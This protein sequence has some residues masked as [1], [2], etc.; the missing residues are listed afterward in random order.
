MTELHEQY[1]RQVNQA[2]AADRMILVE[3]LN[4]EFIEEALRLILATA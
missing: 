2:V 1:A 3:E 4:E